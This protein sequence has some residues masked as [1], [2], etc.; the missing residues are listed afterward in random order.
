VG[1][2]RNLWR[3]IQAPT[4]NEDVDYGNL[5]NIFQSYYE[6][7][8]KFVADILGAVSYNGNLGP[9][10]WQCDVLDALVEHRLIAVRA[11]HGIGKTTGCSFAIH[12]Y[13]TTHYMCKI[14]IVAPTFGKQVKAMIFSEVHA[15]RRKSLLREI[16]TQNQTKMAIIGAENE[17]FAEGVAAEEPDKVEGFH[18]PGG[19]LYIFDEAK[20]IQKK[21][22]DAARG[23]LTG[24]ED[25][26]LAVS[27][28][29]LAPIGEFVRVFT[30]LRATWKT[31]HFGPTPRQSKKWRR[32]REREWPKGSPEYVSKILGEIPKS[33]TDRT[34]I[35]LDLI[36]K[37]MQRQPTAED[38]KGS[39]SVG[40]DV[41][42]YG[43]DETVMAF[44]HGKVIL[45]LETFAKQD[46]A[47]SAKLLEEVLP[48][49]DTAQVDEVAVGAGVVD[50][51]SHHPELKHKLVPVKN[52]D[53]SPDPERY[54]DLGTWMWFMF[55]KWLEDGGVL[56]YD[57]ELCSQLATR[58]FEWHFQHGRMTRKLVSKKDTA[59]NRQKS[60]DRAEA[61]ILAAIGAPKAMVAYLSQA[62][63]DANDKLRL[64]SA[65]LKAEL[66]SRMGKSVK[67]EEVLKDQGPE[68]RRP[69]TFGLRSRR[70]ALTTRQ[71]SQ[72]ERVNPLR[73][74]FWRR[75]RP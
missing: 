35:P 55:V 47:I 65:R 14:P 32:E 30:Q 43:Q 22:W 38:L 60:P 59:K 33:S 2:R 72:D 48:G 54:H 20:G 5:L 45:P 62:D 13:L 42:R 18:A 31:F 70:E 15:W 12:W 37:A 3:L 71:L 24:P 1:Q 29:P 7:P 57:D 21:I 63:M 11:P 46:T 6:N 58:E 53:E 39:T 19:V 4:G 69:D 10:P 27:T 9:D 66:M 25:R 67:A 17:W 56:P 64:E 61:V 41:A 50:P 68:Q 36:E 34:V 49:Y 51:I 28:P 16:Y 8:V 23:A 40:M 75:N 44:R 73:G 74:G 52:N 26:M